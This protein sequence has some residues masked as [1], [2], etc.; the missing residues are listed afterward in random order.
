MHL[1]LSYLL[2]PW[3]F[4][5]F[6]ILLISINEVDFICTVN[7]TCFYTFVWYI[8]GVFLQ[9]YRRLVKHVTSFHLPLSVYISTHSSWEELIG[10][11]GSPLFQFRKFTGELS[12]QE[13]PSDKTKQKFFFSSL[14]I[15]F[16][17]AISF[18]A[19]LN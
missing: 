3:F 16:K 13:N 7:K 5:S 12:R 6:L 8:R 11:D 18:F 4:P 17:L 1:F 15:S 2:I 14:N 10:S 9:T 19:F